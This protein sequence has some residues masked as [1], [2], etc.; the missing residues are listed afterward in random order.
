MTALQISLKD[1]DT[2][3]GRVC[4]CGFNHRI[5]GFLQASSSLIAV[6]STSKLKDNNTSNIE[7]SGLD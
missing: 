5:L 4:K 2:F 7:K 6:F 1:N 3:V